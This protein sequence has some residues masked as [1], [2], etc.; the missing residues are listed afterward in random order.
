M[1]SLELGVD[2]VQVCLYKTETDTEPH[3]T[4]SPGLVMVI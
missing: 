1:P 2:I 4:G 3:P